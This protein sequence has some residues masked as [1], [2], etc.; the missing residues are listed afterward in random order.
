M[1]LFVLYEATTVAR[2]WFIGYWTQ[3]YDTQSTVIRHFAYQ[4]G[5]RPADSRLET[6][7]IDH[8]LSFYL[9]TYFGLSVFMCVLG[10][11]RYLCVF[12]GA[13]RASKRLFDKLT[14]AVLRAPLRW[15]DTTPVGRILNRFTADFTAIDSRLGYDFGFMLYQIVLLAGIVAAGLFVSLWMLLIA[16][17]LLL[18]C[19][20]IT[21]RFLTG[22]REVKVRYF[23]EN[24]DTSAN[25]DF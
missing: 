8:D 14:Y 16:V 12:V 22:A 25:P 20:L 10:A 11:L 3:S 7:S 13:I 2:S 21:R 15:L 1:G 9:G 4:H 18:L 19:A 6:W 17:A 23:L 5:A 24:E